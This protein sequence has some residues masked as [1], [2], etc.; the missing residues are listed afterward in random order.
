MYLYSR[1]SPC[2]QV[3]AN[4]IHGFPDY[5]KCT[6][7]NSC[8][9]KIFNFQ[10]VIN[11]QHIYV[12]WLDEY[13]QRK[14]YNLPLTDDFINQSPEIFYHRDFFFSMRQM[15]SEGTKITTVP[16]VNENVWFQ[17]EMY[18][19][20]NQNSNWKNLDLV[21]KKYDNK[22]KPLTQN[23]RE[24]FIRDL[25]NKL[26]AH[27]VVAFNMEI[28]KEKGPKNYFRSLN[29]WGNAFNVVLEKFNIFFPT[30]Q[31]LRNDDLKTLQSYAKDY[32]NGIF[33]CLEAGKDDLLGPQLNK[34][35]RPSSVENSF[36]NDVNDL[37]TLSLPS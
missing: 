14:D 24:I 22:M 10:T 11:I 21:I 23:D 6:D 4:E 31:L 13:V 18:K 3:T 33:M 32:E 19:C 30:Y 20:L 28:F 2:C 8:S 36:S 27:C 26:T 17:M 7:D 15:M 12:S 29:C 35:P 5:R 37:K 25:I 16:L 9:S 1:F 34:E